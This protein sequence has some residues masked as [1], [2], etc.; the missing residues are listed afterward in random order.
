MMMMMMTSQSRRLY[1]SETKQLQ[2]SHSQQTDTTNCVTL[3]ACGR[4]LICHCISYSHLPQL[5]P[6]QL[7]RHCQLSLMVVLI[8]VM[9]TAATCHKHKSTFHTHL[10][11]FDHS[12]PGS[13]SQRNRTLTY[14]VT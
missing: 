10:L 11:Q 12:L 14:L 13:R 7:L 8:P 1:T 2:V 3:L 9:M 6:T 5:P 4:F